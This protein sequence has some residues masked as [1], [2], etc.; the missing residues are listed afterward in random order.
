LHFHTTHEAHTATALRYS[1]RFAYTVLIGV[2]QSM[3][4]VGYGLGGMQTVVNS[5]SQH[6]CSSSVC[7]QDNEKN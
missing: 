2:E 4:A 5:F 1:S 7:R 6:L 3:F